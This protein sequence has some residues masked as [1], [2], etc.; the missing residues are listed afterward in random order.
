[1]KVLITGAN[2]FLGYYLIEQLLSKQFTVIGTGRGECRLPF[3]QQKHFTYRQMDFTDPFQVH[4]VFEN[5]APEIVIHAGAMSKPDDCELDQWEAYRTNTEA[6]VTLLVNAEEH[7]SLFVFVSTDFIFDGERGMYREQDKPGPVNFYGKTKLEAEEAVKEYQ[8]QWAIVRTV[9]VYGKPQAGRENIL[10]IV[11]KK[12]ENGEIY[13]V[14][15]DQVRTPTYV[16]DLAAGIISVIETKASGIFHLSGEEVL[17]PYQMAIRAA[18][19]L[20]LDS[21]LINKVTAAN[22]SQPAKRPA[23]TG[24]I[25]D[26][27][28]RELGYKPLSFDEG[29]KRTFE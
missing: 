5:Y 1:M 14:V 7:K 2:G 15:D 27:A 10:T 24:F 17:T 22:F 16:G 9:L 20:R 21:S 26:K 8:Y 29:L 25:I 11:K 23:K 3:M 6:T 12:L 4:D 28:R 19:F 18:D 13:N